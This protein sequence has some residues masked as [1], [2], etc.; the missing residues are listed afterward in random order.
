M[1]ELSAR[2]ELET[3]FAAPAERIPYTTVNTGSAPILIGEDYGVERR[4]GEKWVPVEIRV[5]VR[6]I[7]Y[8][9][10]P[11]HRRSLT[12]AIPGGLA[13]GHYR[14]RKTALADPSGPE[15]PLDSTVVVAEFDV[16][17]G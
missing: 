17:S 15:R 16:V 12:A 11:G 3:T 2:L 13:P 9:L 10:D 4:A 1:S 5:I 7:G 14:L 6:A 8:G